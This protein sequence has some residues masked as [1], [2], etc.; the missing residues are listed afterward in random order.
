M[1]RELRILW[2]D[3]DAWFCGTVDGYDSIS[4]QHMVWHPST[5][6]FRQSSAFH[7]GKR[8]SSASG[9]MNATDDGQQPLEGSSLQ[10]HV[11]ANLVLQV[12]YADGDSESIL[13][14]ME[15]VRLSVSP[16]EKL[17]VPT[18]NELTATAQHLLSAVDAASDKEKTGEQVL[19]YLPTLT[20]FAS[21][22]EV[23]MHMTPI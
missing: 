4:G 16:G 9:R 11:K 1:G 13:L 2:P 14:P 8:Q 22:I 17:A 18:A 20:L 3:D 23:G 15:R 10:Q 21:G 19:Q 7:D 6:R 5:A 12:M